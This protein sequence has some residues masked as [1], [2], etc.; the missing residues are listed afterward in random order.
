[1]AKR[2]AMIPVILIT[3]LFFLWGLANNMT[4]T[5]L[6]AFKKIMSMTD[7]QTSLIQMAFYGA[8]FVLALPAALYIRRFSYKSGI[9]LGL[10]LFILGAML[11]YPA[12]QTMVYGHFLAALFVLAGGLSI[13][14]TS[15]NPFILSLGPPETATRRLNLAQSFNPIGSITGVILSKYVIL[16]ALHQAGDE[17][18]IRMDHSALEQIQRAELSAVMQAYVGLA[19]LLIVV[20]L[21]IKMVRMP[22]DIDTDRG[23]VWAA[24]G[25]LSRNRNYVYGVIAQFFYVGAQIG[26]WSFT[27]R[28]VMQELQVNEES[29]SN[30]YI[31]SLVF[32]MLSRFITTGL[33]K[34]VKPTRLLLALALAAVVLCLVVSLTGGQT[35]VYA[36]VAVSACMSLMF[37]T[38]YGLASEGLSDDRKI[39]GSGLIMAILGGAVLTYLQGLVS[40]GL[41]NINISFLVPALC[42]AAVAGYGWYRENKKNSS[43]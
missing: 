9:L 21:L 33:M 13:L 34:F 15:A 41:G 18:R 14:E 12:S 16:S 22:Q 8:Y 2:Y 37:P 24:F 7:A 4:D 6:A 20:W 43:I 5:L 42:F 10:G 32:F 26:V 38:I 1:M 30:Y 27:I 28:Y 40:D 25:R 3:S 23:N 11:F 17:E 39:G 29:A 36:L 31:L 19:M 35:G